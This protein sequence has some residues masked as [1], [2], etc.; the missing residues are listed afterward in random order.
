MEDLLDGPR[1]KRL[2]SYNTRWNSV[3]SLT[4]LRGAW[5][6]SGPRTLPSRMN[7]HCT[8]D[9]GGPPPTTPCTHSRFRLRATRSVAVAQILTEVGV[10]RDSHSAPEKQPMHRG[11]RLVAHQ[12][13]HFL[14]KRDGPKALNIGVARTAMKYLHREE[15]SMK[16]CCMNARRAK[17]RPRAEYN[18]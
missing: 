13:Q 8:P 17:L 7:K 14:D 2:V 11:Q 10:R 16:A 18:S 12:S 6:N 15:W 4:P 9:D 5:G 3:K 1:A